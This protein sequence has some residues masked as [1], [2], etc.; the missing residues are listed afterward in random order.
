M[1]K[2]DGAASDMS[3][4]QISIPGNL[5]NG[6]GA[7]GTDDAKKKVLTKKKS[8]MGIANANTD[9]SKTM[10]SLTTR[11]NQRLPHSTLSVSTP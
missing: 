2:A 4:S 7:G 11:Q 6:G 9:L 1:R 3:S 5:I 8:W 10:Q